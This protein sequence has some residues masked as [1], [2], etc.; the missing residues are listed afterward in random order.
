MTIDSLVKTGYVAFGAGG[1]G[2]LWL[3]V[4][5]MSYSGAHPGTQLSGVLEV[6]GL[7]I[8]A[9]A[10]GG[11]VGMAALRRLATDDRD[12]NKSAK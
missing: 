9:I 3:F 4:H 8:A 5:E 11:V 2:G 10:G 7:A 6:A 1:A 12:V